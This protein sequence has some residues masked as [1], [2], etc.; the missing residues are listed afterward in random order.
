M[1]ELQLM[2]EVVGGEEALLTLSP[3]L[4]LLVRGRGGIV[5]TVT[6][7]LVQVRWVL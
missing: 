3:G 4:C 5:M 7:S 2:D 1:R 6:G